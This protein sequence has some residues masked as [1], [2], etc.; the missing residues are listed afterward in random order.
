MEKDRIIAGQ[1]HVE[2]RRN[3]CW[4]DLKR[5][6]RMILSCH[7]SVGLLRLHKKS[8]QLANNF[9]YCR[10]EVAARQSRDRTA[11]GDAK[12]AKNRSIEPLWLL[13]LPL[14]G[15]VKPVFLTDLHFTLCFSMF[16]VFS[17][18]SHSGF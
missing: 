11:L 3:H 15:W 17:G 9:D 7:D 8:S 2:Q 4:Q 14:T 13:R 1:N 10:A 12:H 18:E 16:R 6:G 5:Q